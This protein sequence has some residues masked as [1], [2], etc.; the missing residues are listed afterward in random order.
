M[1]KLFLTWMDVTN[2]LVS[3]DEVTCST[4]AAQVFLPKLL[5]GKISLG[6]LGVIL[7]LAGKD[8]L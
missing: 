3:Q 5:L 4:A 8:P 6:S 1:K 7:S 2:E